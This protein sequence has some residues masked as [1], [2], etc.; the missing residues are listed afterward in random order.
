MSARGRVWPPAPVAQPLRLAS[1]GVI[2][3][4]AMALFLRN[5]YLGT[6]MDEIAA[7]AGVSKQTVYTHFADKEQLFTDLVRGNTNIAQEFI[8][9]M[10][11]SLRDTDDLETDL[12]VLARRYVTTV[13]QPRVLQLRRLVIG[14]SGRFPELARSY[15]EL[16]PERVISTLASC[17]QVLADRGLLRLDDPLL[18]AKHLAWLILAAPLDKSMFCG[19]D[20]FSSVE[21]ERFA[22]AGVRV[23]LAAYAA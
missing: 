7:D 6:S 12:G 21:L 5:G 14:E 22:D 15:Y 19:D 13:I 4:A 2:R 8:D 17:L 16:V 1:G 11:Q 20:C 23:F 9:H 10:N 18:A 3:E